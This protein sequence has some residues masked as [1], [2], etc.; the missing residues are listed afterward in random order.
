MRTLW[1]ACWPR[2]RTV[3]IAAGA[4]ALTCGWLAAADPPPTVEEEAR[5]LEAARAVAR[6]YIS[7][8]PDFLCTE[9]V[10]RYAVPAN[11]KERLMDTLTVEVDYYDHEEHDEVA[12]VNGRPADPDSPLPNG[13]QSS[14]LFTST[15]ARVLT[16]QADFHFARWSVVN[17]RAAAI[18]SYR[19]GWLDAMFAL[20]YLDPDGNESDAMVGL[21]GEVAIDRETYGVLRF[22]YAADGVP[23]SFPMRGS[24]AVEYDS[25]ALGGGRY[26]LPVKAVL[27]SSHGRTEDRDEVDFLSYRKIASTPEF[28]PGEPPPQR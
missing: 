10:R 19:A 9:T 14:G 15:M 2:I 28:S 25:I 13:V 4:L 12:K 6:N 16:S 7:S 26:L 20:H 5:F 11:G 23:D 22:E 24:G 8:L 21:R 27:R 17:A 3:A 1:P 18:Y